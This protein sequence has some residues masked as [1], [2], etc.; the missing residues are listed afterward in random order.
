MRIYEFLKSGE[1]PFPD[2]NYGEGFRCSV[3]L[4][5]GLFLPCVMIRKNRIYIDLACRR[6][7][8]E[9]NGKSVFLNKE[10]GYRE[11]VK[12]FV[13][14]GNR[15]ND[16]DVESVEKSRFAIPLSLLQKMKVKLLCH[17]QGLFLK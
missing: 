10:S 2:A 17:G 7:D 12:S 15:I 11:I 14:Q 4:K 5:G 9:R 16:Y 3:R 8:D 1:E 13:T 6:F